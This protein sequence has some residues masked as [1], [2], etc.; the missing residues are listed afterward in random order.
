MIPLS[1]LSELNV[2]VDEAVSV[3]VPTPVA[4]VIAPAPVIAIE[5]EEIMLV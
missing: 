1:V 3:V 2:T 5:G 4:P